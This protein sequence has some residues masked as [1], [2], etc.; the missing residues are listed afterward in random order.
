MGDLK[1]FEVAHAVFLFLTNWKASL[2][3]VVLGSWEPPH[4]EPLRY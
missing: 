1:Y 3:R 2:N 4:H